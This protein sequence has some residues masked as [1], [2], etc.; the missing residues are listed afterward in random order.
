MKKNRL[1]HKIGLKTVK[2]EEN[3]AAIIFVHGLRGHLYDTWTKNECEPLPFIMKQDPLYQDFDLFTFGYKTGVFLKRSHF[4][5]VS[6]LLLSEIEA[7]T[8]HDDIYFIVHSMG[9]LVIQSLLINQVE[10]G[11]EDLIKKVKGII[12]LAVP[13][14]GAT[15][16]SAISFTYTLLPPLIGEYAF[17]SQVRS[18]KIFDKDLEEQ[19]EKWVRY[20]DNQIS[21][22]VQKNIYGQSDAVVHRFSA[23][24]PYIQDANV[25]EENHRSICKMDKDSTVY[26]L[27]S[28]FIKKKTMN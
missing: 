1:E 19:A 28:Q 4:K 17:S 18:L 5:D 11:N 13:F 25:V 22:I 10:S 8:Q 20:S 14:Y 3:S 21:H 24:P 2:Q 27:I 7:R 9:G 15:G 16:G 6:K 23:K 26:R 12:Y